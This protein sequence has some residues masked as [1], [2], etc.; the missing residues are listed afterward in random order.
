M[1][2]HMDLP[3]RFFMVAVPQAMSEVLMVIDSDSDNEKKK[4]VAY[5]KLFVYV[6]CSKQL[7]NFKPFQKGFCFNCKAF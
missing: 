5:L 7:H 1:T 4:A 6:E 3:T 2:Y